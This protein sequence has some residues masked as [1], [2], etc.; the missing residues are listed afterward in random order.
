MSLKF[1]ENVASFCGKIAASYRAYW[2]RANQ[3]IQ[4]ER[5]QRQD[6]NK[7]NE[8]LLVYPSYAAA[9][10][11]SINNVRTKFDIIPVT[12]YTQVYVTRKVMQTKQDVYVMLFRARYRNSPTAT[13]S[14]LCR[15]LQDELDVL[16]DDAGL[17]PVRISVRYSPDDTI[18]IFM[19]RVSDIT[20]ATLQKVKI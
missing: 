1:L 14:I 6:Q 10:M 7:I 15:N 5:K 9:V 20:A 11:Q 16:C 8:L 12:D 3:Q 4:E 18:G 17:E 13:A 19:A 2:E